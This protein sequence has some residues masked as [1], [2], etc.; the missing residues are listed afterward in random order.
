MGPNVTSFETITTTSCN[1]ETPLSTDQGIGHFSEPACK[2]L[3]KRTIS[4]PP[5]KLS[6]PG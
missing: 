1:L 5:G 2:W 6:A 3:A 4:A